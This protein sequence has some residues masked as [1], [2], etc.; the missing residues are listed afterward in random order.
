MSIAKGFYEDQYNKFVEM[1]KLE[2]ESWSGDG[3]RT[4]RETGLATSGHKG[5]FGSEEICVGS[6]FFF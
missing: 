1:A 6:S 5:T 4:D 2:R 3:N